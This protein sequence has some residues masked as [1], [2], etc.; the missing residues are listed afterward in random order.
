MQNPHCHFSIDEPIGSF[1]PVQG[2]D[3]ETA[4]VC[5]ANGYAN[6]VQRRG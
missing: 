2:V 6:E 1:S 4:G 3:G 5:L